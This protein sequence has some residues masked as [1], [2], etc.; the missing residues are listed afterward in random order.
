LAEAWIIAIGVGAAGVS[1]TPSI[2]T[3]AVLGIVIIAALWWAYFDVYAVEAQRR[4]SKLSGVPRT[5]PATST[6][7]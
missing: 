5:R 2:V 3:A 6:C 1:L 7:R 4:L